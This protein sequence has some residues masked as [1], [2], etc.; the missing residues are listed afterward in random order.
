M[1]KTTSSKKVKFVCHKCLTETE[2]PEQCPYCQSWKLATLGVGA[3]RVEEEIKKLF[4]TA[5]VF[6]IDSDLVKTK[7]QGDEIANNFYKNQGAVLV[8]TES[9]FSYIKKPVESVGV[10]SIDAAFT[11]PD[12]KV[13]EKVFYLLLKLRSLAKDNFLIQTRTPNLKLFDDAIKGHITGFYQEEL[14]ERKRFGY[15]PFKMIIKVTKGN[16]DKSALQKEVKHFV[17]QLKD[18]EVVDYPAFIP[19]EKNLYKWN[20][21]IKVDPTA[22][23]KGLAKL[24]SFLFYLPSGWRVDVEPDSLL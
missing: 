5:N 16:A 17:E 8:G 2:A 14:E 19:K 18:F 23:P 1:H 3:Q 24:H 20:V 10:V 13:N 6:R 9:L 11:L 12:F 21:I 22:W 4:P 7:K 15:P